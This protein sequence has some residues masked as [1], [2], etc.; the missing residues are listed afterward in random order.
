MSNPTDNDDKAFYAMMKDFVNTYRN[1][2]ASTDDFRMIANQHFVNTP[3]A[4][5][6]GLKNLDWFFAQWVYSTYL[7]SYRLEYTI[8]DQPDGTFLVSGNVLQTNAPENWFM[9]IPV[10]IAFGEK[11]F[12]SG[13]LVANGAKSPFS[14]KLPN[15]PTKMVLDPNQWILS[16]KTS[17]Q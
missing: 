9:P 1:K 8:Q 5:K 11:Q 3:I 10:V 14:I 6:Y 16:E 15:K 7:P 4:K 12:A 13:T 17:T 2:V